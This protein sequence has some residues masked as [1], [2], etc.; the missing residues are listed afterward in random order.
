MPH[1]VKTLTSSFGLLRLWVFLEKR[2]KCKFLIIAVQP[3]PSQPFIALDLELL[4]G[5]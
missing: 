2:G 1:S 4:M 3:E 5:N